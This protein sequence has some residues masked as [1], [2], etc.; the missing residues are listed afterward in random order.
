[1][2]EQIMV[3]IP[4]ERYDQL[5]DTEIRVNIAVERIINQKYMQTEDI[6]RILGT[7]DAL[8]E[9]ERIKE[10]NERLSKEWKHE[11]ETHNADV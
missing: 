9:A 6:L 11:M 4:V 1:M 10:E 7:G 5:I 2:S 3:S 8:I